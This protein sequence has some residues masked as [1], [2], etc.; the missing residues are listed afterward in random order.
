MKS[1]CKYPITALLC[2]FVLPP[3]PPP[4]HFLTPPDDLLG[5]T[6]PE[7]CIART[8]FRPLMDFATQVERARDGLRMITTPS[9]QQRKE[10]VSHGPPDSPKLIK[11]LNKIYKTSEW[12]SWYL[13]YCTSYVCQ[14]LNRESESAVQ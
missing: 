13:H 9:G 5:S 10:V 2:F 14:G 8:L 1:R 3:P 7:K 6:Y 11:M 12:E 4:P